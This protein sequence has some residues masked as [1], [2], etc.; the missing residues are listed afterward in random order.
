MGFKSKINVPWRLG[1]GSAIVITT[2]A[3][4]CKN[5]WRDMMHFYQQAQSLVALSEVPAAAAPLFKRISDP[6]R[7]L[8][9]VLSEDA[10]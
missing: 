7:V 2:V 1:I 6:R 4:P 9:P 5:R 3:G 8:K 10:P